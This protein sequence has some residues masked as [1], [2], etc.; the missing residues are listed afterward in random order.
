MKLSDK[1]YVHFNGE[2]LSSENGQVP[3]TELAWFTAM[4]EAEGSITASASIRPNGNLSLVPIVLFTNQDEEIIGEV[5]R[6][7]EKLNID[8]K[9]FWRKSD[10]NGNRMCN[11]RIDK[12]QQVKQ[13]LLLIQPYMRSF[14][15]RNAKVIL[16]FIDSRDKNRFL[17]NAK[18]HIL[19][20]KYSKAECEMVA[21]IRTHQRALPLSHMLI[22]SNVA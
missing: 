2:G 9:T 16:D 8:H 21:S 11:L 7:L 19:R 6:I 14:K 15:R 13:I 22:A 10:K 4:I 5:R 1:I 3:E 20:N 18:G 12:F 17:R